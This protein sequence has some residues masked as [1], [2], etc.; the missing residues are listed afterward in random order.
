[1][2]QGFNIRSV[3]NSITN[4]YIIDA[5]TGKT[6]TQPINTNG[7]FS[8]N[9]WGGINYKLKKLKTNIDIS[10]N[11]GYYKNTDVVNG[12]FNQSKTF[13]GGLRLGL[14]KSSEKKYDI[15]ISDNFNYNRN[16]TTQNNNINSYFTNS[17]NIYTTVY[18]KKVWSLTTDYNFMSRQKTQQFQDNLTNSI[19]N[20]RFQK[21]FKDNEF[22]AYFMVRDILNQNIGVDRNYSGITTTEETNQRLKRYF[23]IWFTWDFK[24]AGSKPAPKTP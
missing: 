2:Y 10:P 11:A 22:T 13:N 24:N 12:Q 14:Y 23:M 4:S 3:A 8:L 9:F 18:Y 21:T 19:W 15:S 17:V 16:T 20:A 1:M 6:T 7:N 5:S